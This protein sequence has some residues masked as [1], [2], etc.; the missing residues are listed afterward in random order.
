MMVMVVVTMVASYPLK[1][2]TF[3]FG[4]FVHADTEVRPDFRGGD[5]HGAV[6]SLFPISVLSVPFLFPFLSS[7]LSDFNL[8]CRVQSEW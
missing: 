1:P 6:A 4:A 7:L 8:R 3:P 2:G 5:R